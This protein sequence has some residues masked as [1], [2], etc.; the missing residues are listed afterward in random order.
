MPIRRISVGWTLNELQDTLI[1]KPFILYSLIMA[2]RES[3]NPTI[4]LVDDERIN[5]TIYSKCLSHFYNV[6]TAQSG[7]QALALLDGDCY[8]D[9]IILDVMMPNMDGYQV[10][11]QI[12]ANPKI[13]NIPVIIF[14]ALGEYPEK[15]LG[16]ELG[17]IG[18]LAKPCSL[19]SLLFE[20]DAQLKAACSSDYAE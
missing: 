9:L 6:V 13:C 11:S 17:A 7:E 4:L 16:F 5:L 2:T 18:Y 15:K 3:R 14:S 12:K 8:P 1:H 19:Q 20:V 10:I